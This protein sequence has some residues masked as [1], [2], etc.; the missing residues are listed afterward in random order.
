M[1]NIKRLPNQQKISITYLLELIDCM[2]A[3]KFD[4]VIK[5]NRETLISKP[6]N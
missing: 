2:S 4:Q 5:R 6:L 1:P 3:F